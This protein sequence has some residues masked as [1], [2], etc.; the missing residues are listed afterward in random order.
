MGCGNGVVSIG[1]IRDL[2]QVCVLVVAVLRWCVRW[3]AVLGT[4]QGMPPPAVC[5]NG[6]E[7]AVLTGCR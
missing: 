3:V 2:L 7:P 4:N 1:L 5:T 6:L